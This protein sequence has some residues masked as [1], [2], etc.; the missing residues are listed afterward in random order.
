MTIIVIISTSC[1]QDKKKRVKFGNGVPASVKEALELDKDNRN[2]LWSLKAPNHHHLI[3]QLDFK[4][5]ARL[6]A[7]GD[8]T[9]PPS[10][11]TYSSVVVRE[12]LRI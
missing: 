6:M 8:F 10:Y 1:K 7:K 11:I 2:N 5:K 3:N 4:R 9:E 12:S